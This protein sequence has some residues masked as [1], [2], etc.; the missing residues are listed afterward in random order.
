MFENGNQSRWY[1]TWWGVTLAGLGLLL[2]VAIILIGATTIKYWWQL[3]NGQTTFFEAN[4]K[5][6]TASRTAGV[7][8]KVDRSKLEI[9]DDPYLGRESAPITIV[10][11]ADFKC[12]NSKAS[13]PIIQEVARKF[14][15]KVKIIVRDFPAESKFPGSSFLSQMAY[16]A[17]KQGKYWEMHRFLFENQDSL[18]DAFTAD[19]VK[20][21]AAKVGAEP[22]QLAS[23]SFSD[24]AI[25]EVKLDFLAGVEAGVVGPPT[26]F[27]NGQKVEGSLPYEVWSKY[28]E[29]V[30]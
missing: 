7:K 21:I 22:N 4:L 12:P 16:C 20:T 17:Q 9:S 28:L 5:E 2:L 29:S 10:E 27:V 14:G 24:E 11:F 23:C 26:F 18:D 1:Q 19:E 15:Y 6:F 30:K 25:R 3:K 8:A 13:A